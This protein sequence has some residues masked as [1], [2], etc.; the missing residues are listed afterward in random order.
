M[1]H[2]QFVDLFRHL[3]AGF[4][5]VVNM[6]LLL[7]QGSVLRLLRGLPLQKCLIELIIFPRTDGRAL[8]DR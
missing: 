8:P 5:Q 4:F 7:P 2:L 3:I 1:D 6:G